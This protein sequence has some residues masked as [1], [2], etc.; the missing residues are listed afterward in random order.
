M[1]SP[2]A[3]LPARFPS[4]Y[5]AGNANASSLTGKAVGLRGILTAE[6]G[7]QKEKRG[8]EEKKSGFVAVFMRVVHELQQGEATMTP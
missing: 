5:Q 1:T 8:M 6:L 7:K 2:E 4:G 3:D